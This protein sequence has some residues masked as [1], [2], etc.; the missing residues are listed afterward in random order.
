[1]ALI[2]P[3]QLYS[4]SNFNKIHTAFTQH[5]PNYLFNN[6]HLSKTVIAIPTV[7]LAVTYHPQQA[8]QQLRMQIKLDS[9]QDRALRFVEL[10]SQESRVQIENFGVHG[11]LCLNMHTHFSDIDLSVYGANNFRKVMDTVQ[12][13]IL[14]DELVA[15]FEHE[16]DR[17]RKNKG[18]FEDTKFVLNAIRQYSEI[19]EMYGDYSYHPLQPVKLCCDVSD[20]QE[21]FF[22]PAIYGITN[23]HPPLSSLIADVD[24]DPTSLISMI[25]QYRGI[26]QKRQS[27]QA[28]GMVEKVTNTTSRIE[29]RVVI[30]SGKIGPEEYIWPVSN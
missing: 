13:L 15:L 7:D 17:Y 21:A 19:T 25:G 5:Y 11:S 20:D 18:L 10:L 27:V 12:K 30:G 24:E 23:C 8:L 14:Q 22:K 3:R 26:A 4:P 29:Y 28:F 1:M 2:R 6:P 9:L 16:S